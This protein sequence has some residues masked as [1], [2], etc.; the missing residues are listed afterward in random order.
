M[1][2]IFTAVAFKGIFRVKKQKKS[3]R[4]HT[5]GVF[6]NCTNDF[7]PTNCTATLAPVLACDVIIQ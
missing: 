3:Q 1:F 6:R 4:F 7:V 2:L 5:K